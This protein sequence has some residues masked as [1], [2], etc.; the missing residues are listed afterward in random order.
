MDQ[1]ERV[2]RAGDRF[3]RVCSSLVAARRE[4]QRL[5]KHRD[6]CRKAWDREVTRKEGRELDDMAAARASRTAMEVEA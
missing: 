6:R 3:E 1:Q 2:D 4:V 5:E